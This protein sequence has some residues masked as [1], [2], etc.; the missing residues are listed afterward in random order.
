MKKDGKKYRR[1]WVSAVCYGLAAAMLIYV[2]FQ[3]GN[4]VKTINEYYAQYGMSAQPLEYIT[5]CL[6]SAL[7]PIVYTVAFFMFGYIL[8]EV[9]KNNKAYYLTDEEL[10][11]MAAAKKEAR[12]A[13]KFAKGE[14]AAA[15]A[16]YVAPAENSVEADFAKSLDAEL[17][18]EGKKAEKKAESKPENKGENKKPRSN[19]NR[20]N[21]NRQGGS[22]PNTNRNKSEGGS[23]NDN[24]GNK[25]G[26]Q[27]KNSNRKPADKP[28]LE[29]ATK[30]KA[31]DGFEVKINDK[32]N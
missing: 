9:R 18:A 26:G 20:Q 29:D 3:I 28:K 4:T 19:Y 30:T 22:K 5:Y 27:R 13:K 12:E 23:K 16:G 15:K 10:V 2:C 11:E 31:D 25:S 6:Q 1:N 21:Q 14:K 17:K 24:G 32:E 7:E 8:D